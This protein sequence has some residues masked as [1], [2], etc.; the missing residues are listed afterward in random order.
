ML[1]LYFSC[2]S[3][4][5]PPI[6][7]PPVEENPTEDWENVLMKSIHKN[8]D[9]SVGV[10]YAFI[11]KNHD[12]LDKYIDWI[13]KHGP[14]S[15]K[16]R[17]RD[18]KRKLAFLLNAYNAS[19]IYSV[20]DNNLHSSDKGVLD[21]S[22]GMFPKGGSGFFLGQQFF[23]DGEWVSLFVLEQQ[24]ILGN[25]QDPLL[26]A[27]M[28]C[29]S[30]GCPPL[31]FWKE[32]TVKTKLK[33]HFKTF[34]NSS[35]GMQKIDDQ[36]QVSELFEWYEKDFVQWSNASNLCE[37]LHEYTADEDAKTY[38]KTQATQNCELQFFAYDWSLNTISK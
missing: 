2:Q 20:L 16:M 15:D 19:V 33:T 11:E 5:A 1:L 17:I 34:L 23:I 26:H 7:E 3:Q 35:F 9:G 28:N 24:Y 37:Y 36:W 18:S 22:A 12:T 27:G 21:V 6:E 13:G 10:D 29:A 31:T 38:L 32:K 8:E 14:F 4:I 25:F 30:K